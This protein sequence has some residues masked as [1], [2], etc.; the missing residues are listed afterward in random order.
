MNFDMLWNKIPRNQDVH[1]TV[2]SLI[3]SAISINFLL[4]EVFKN[5]LMH[6]S[7]SLPLVFDQ[8]KIKLSYLEYKPT[9]TF[10]HYLINFLNR[11]HLYDIIYRKLM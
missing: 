4:L 3:K 7:K 5:Y 10:L 8:E 6:S 2:I 1:K 9:K 11:F